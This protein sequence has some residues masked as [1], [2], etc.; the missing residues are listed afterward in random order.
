MSPGG[1]AAKVHARLLAIAH[2][3][4][5][6]FNH[7]LGRYAVERFLYRLSLSPAR[8]QFVLKGALLFDL[9]FDA[10][11]RPTRDADVLASGSADVLALTDTVRSLCVMAIDDGMQYAPETV[12]LAEIREAASY[13]GFRVRLRGQLGTAFS[14]VQLDV[15]YGD[16]M[17]LAPIAADLPVLLNGSPAPRL[18]MYRREVAKN[19]LQAPSLEVVVHEL[20][21]WL[22]PLMR[23]ART[24]PRRP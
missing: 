24:L 22:L 23:R 9:W 10:P 4:S 11:H 17:A 3:R 7:V 8:D 15:G 16:A 2:G 18:L 5:Q 14:V 20:G 19:R 6:D 13:A 1:R 21:T 12:V